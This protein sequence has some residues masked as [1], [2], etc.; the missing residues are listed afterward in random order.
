MAT[1]ILDYTLADLYARDGDASNLV[2]VFANP[3]PRTNSC[4]PKYTYQSP[5][6]PT[7]TRVSS[8]RRRLHNHPLKMSFLAGKMLVTFLD[9]D[10]YPTE[11]PSG[12]KD[13][14][15][16]VLEYLHPSQ[17]PMLTFASSLANIKLPSD[18]RV[19]VLCPL[20]GVSH[21]THAVNPDV[22]YDLLSK[23]S[24]AY[25]GL[26]TPETTIVDCIPQIEFSPSEIE[27]EVQRMIRPI[28]QKEIPFIVKAPQ[29][30]GGLGTFIL[31]TEDQRQA[32][33]KLLQIELRKMLQAV[34][35]F[36]QN[37]H[38]CCL[39]LQEFV[40]GETVGLN[41]FVTQ[42]GRVIFISCS[43]QEMSPKGFWGGGILSYPQ[44]PELEK[45]FS[46]LMG[47]IAKYLHKRGYYGPAGVDVMFDKDGGPLV[48]DFNVR[49]TGSYA[50]G[51][52]KGHFLDRGL[53][54]A[55]IHACN[56]HCSQREFRQHFE[57]EL[58]SGSIVLTAWTSDLVDGSSLAS[59][60]MAAPDQDQL[61]TLVTRVKS[62]VSPPAERQP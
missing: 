24:L 51:C 61:H 14:A 55:M 9:L 60:C 58:E 52:L 34:N 28:H 38:P 25:S 48:V 44:Q 47:Q 27:D 26:P 36:N 10:L 30:I 18:K 33:S 31:Q 54:E 19:V 17:R 7:S 16:E 42:R 22:H 37:L 46:M 15:S 21:L 49:M 45:R 62:F 11:S 35:P 59:V 40:P 2:A 1:I 41:M 39:V 57:R 56:P 29:A 6:V 8:E 53:P 20:D 5:W 4:P 43:T 50:L 13:D 12:H 23:R 32:A 3:T